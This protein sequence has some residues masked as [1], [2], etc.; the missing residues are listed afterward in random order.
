MESAKLSFP[1]K[2]HNAFPFKFGTDI[3]AVLESKNQHFAML[4][5]EAVLCESLTL[6]LASSF[7]FQLPSNPTF[8][9]T[10]SLVSFRALFRIHSKN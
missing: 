10:Y 6:T 4:M 8:Q 1:E 5:A 3:T 7:A 2:L 9:V